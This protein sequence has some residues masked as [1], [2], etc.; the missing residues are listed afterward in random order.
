MI[1]KYEGVIS[2]DFK[3]HNLA[4]ASWGYPPGS[5]EQTVKFVLTDRRKWQMNNNRPLTADEFIGP[6]SRTYMMD[7]N[8]KQAMDDWTQQ[9]TGDADRGKA[10]DGDAEASGKDK[11]DKKGKGKGKGK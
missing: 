1:E 8:E 6:L 11:K 4:E 9:W 7:Q 10:D 2:D 3:L 5:I